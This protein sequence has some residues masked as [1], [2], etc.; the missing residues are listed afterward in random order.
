MKQIIFRHELPSD[1]DAIAE[2]INMA[3]SKVEASGGNEST[4]VEG[5]RLSG[6]LSVSLVVT[7]NDTIVGHI[8]VSPVL[9]NRV[10]RGWFGLGPVAVLPQVQRQG[11][12]S[13]LVRLALENLF[14]KGA[15]GCV[16]LGDPSYYSRFGFSSGNGLVYAGVP[17][18]QFMSR[19]FSA[20]TPSGFVS[21]HPVFTEV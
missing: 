16:L 9:I 19:S 2:V 21:Y 20:Q 14:R 11:I 8:A 15:K 17:G 5:L 1:I 18:E 4:V 3:F 7:L 12:G 13:K 10:D 6:A